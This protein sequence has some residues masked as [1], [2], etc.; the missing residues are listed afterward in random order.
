MVIYGEFGKLSIPKSLSTEKIYEI[1]GRITGSTPY[2]FLYKN[3][4]QV[5]DDCNVLNCTL[6][7]NFR[8]EL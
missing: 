1:K 4:S 7:G 3:I 6:P 5:T 8:N 2:N